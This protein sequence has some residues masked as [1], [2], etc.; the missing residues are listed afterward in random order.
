M[1]LSLSKLKCSISYLF[2]AQQMSSPIDSSVNRPH[3]TVLSV[4]VMQPSPKT[5][6]KISS[7]L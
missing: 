7:Q 2:F 5:S 6:P 4:T 3:G 1:Y